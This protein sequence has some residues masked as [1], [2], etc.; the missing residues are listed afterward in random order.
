VSAKGPGPV[1]AKTSPNLHSSTTVLDS[2]GSDEIATGKR[3]QSS[4]STT[5]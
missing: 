2:L 5:E 4:K 3:K 1:A